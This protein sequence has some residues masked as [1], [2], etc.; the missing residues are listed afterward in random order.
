MQPIVD[1]LE[2]DYEGQI[3]VQRVNAYEGDGPAIMAAYQIK[4]HPT[5]L[6]IDRQ[7]QEVN[8]LIGPQSP[9]KLAEALQPVLTPAAS[10]TGAVDTSTSLQPLPTL[11]ATE[12]A[13]GRQVYGAQCAACHG[14]KGEGQPN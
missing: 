11:D 2:R 9:E 4:G 8:R 5:F 10:Q 13:L 14:Q 1:G 7:G 6:I 12:I 3:F